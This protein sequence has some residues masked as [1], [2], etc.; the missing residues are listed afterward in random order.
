MWPSAAV[1]V[2]GGKSKRCVYPMKNWDSLNSDANFLYALKVESRLLEPII[3][4]RPPG[5]ISYGSERTGEYE[6][7][8]VS[9]RIYVALLAGESRFLA[10]HSSVTADSLQW[11][12]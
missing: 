5:H 4:G 2:R 8:Y 7:S 6:S 1:D 12:Y 9:S 3:R 10:I 11:I